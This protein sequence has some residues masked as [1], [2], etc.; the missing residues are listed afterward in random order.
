MISPF[1]FL[2]GI[3]FPTA[4]QLLQRNTMEH[5]VPWMYGVNGT[6]SVLGSVIAVVLS[7]IAGFTISFFVGLLFYAN[8]AVLVQSN[9]KGIATVERLE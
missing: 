9:S 6:M 2:L 4:I 7:M 1:G 8:I 3:P 5:Y